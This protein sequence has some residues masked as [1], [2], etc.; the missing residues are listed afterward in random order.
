VPSDFSAEWYPKGTPTAAPHVDVVP[1]S[2]QL[3]LVPPVLVKL[4]QLTRPSGV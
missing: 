3:P 4:R 2:L 1:T